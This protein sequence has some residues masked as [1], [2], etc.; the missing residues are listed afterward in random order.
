[1][2]V[3]AGV[4][5]S[6]P[7]SV[8]PD[9][10]QNPIMG[11]MQGFTGELDTQL[12]NKTIDER[13]RMLGELI[14]SDNP[15]SDQQMAQFVADVPTKIRGKFL[16]E[17]RGIRD[18]TAEQRNLALQQGKIIGDAAGAMA[19]VLSK[20]DPGKRQMVLEKLKAG[21]AKR[22]GAQGADRIIE[23]L[24]DDLS[25]SG[26]QSTTM[27]L[28]LLSTAGQAMS[29]M[30]QAHTAKSVRGLQPDSNS[31][32]SVASQLYGQGLDARQS[33]I[34]AARQL[35][36]GSFN[37]AEL[38]AL[39]GL[40]LNTGATKPGELNTN[41]VTSTTTGT[42]TGSVTGE[43]AGD[44]LSKFAGLGGTGSQITSPEDSMLAPYQ[45][46]EREKIGK[47]VKPIVQKH[48]EL[49]EKGKK[50]S[51][52]AVAN[53]NAQGNVVS[54]DDF[55]GGGVGPVASPLRQ[56]AQ[57]A[58]SKA[59][60]SAKSKLKGTRN[61][62]LP[63]LSEEQRKE[64]EKVVSAWGNKMGGKEMQQIVAIANRLGLN[65]AQTK[66]LILEAGKLWNPQR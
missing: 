13:L 6:N 8:Q 23:E 9:R 46:N 11:A 3:I 49:Q 52:K 30:G 65:K 62:N 55:P 66:E 32:I 40:I 50:A 12:Q 53:R 15:P 19:M 54:P 51:D 14:G 4:N 10:S 17:L 64:V 41:T 16:E 59:L 37:E 58:A 36:L 29:A 38:A 63:G 28:S 31:L 7:D 35:G 21:A 44:V 56:Q 1:M 2:S 43:G 5:F 27:R 34:I 24:C 26:L 45:G 18:A 39:E 48:K 25:A 60:E 42:V 20:T 33:L 61:M 57:G 47:A 22:Y